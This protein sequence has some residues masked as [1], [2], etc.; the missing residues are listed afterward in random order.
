MS[1][2]SFRTRAGLLIALLAAGLTLVVLYLLAPRARSVRH[3]RVGSDTAPP[4]THRGAGGRA[5]G[6]AVDVLNEAARRRGIV[7]HW[8]TP[9]GAAEKALEETRVDLWAVS[10]ST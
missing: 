5:E 1:S 9:G 3:L 10:R 7:L 8:T 6:L 4:F 2:L